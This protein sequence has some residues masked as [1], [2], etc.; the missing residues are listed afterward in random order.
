MWFLVVK[1]DPEASTEDMVI[2]GGEEAFEE[3]INGYETVIVRS[4]P[5]KFDT[6]KKV[7]SLILGEPRG[8][9]LSVP[10]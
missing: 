3:S 9:T 6:C 10:C 1:F 2:G 8:A 7:N 4:L 5:N